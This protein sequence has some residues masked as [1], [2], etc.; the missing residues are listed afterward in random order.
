MSRRDGGI[1]AILLP[2][3]AKSYAPGYGSLVA[4]AASTYSGRPVPSWGP[5]G[6]ASLTVAVPL[7]EAEGNRIR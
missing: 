7:Y 6:E 1:G 5:E 4:S 3:Y 2:G